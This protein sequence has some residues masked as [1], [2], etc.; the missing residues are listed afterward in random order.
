M[1]PALAVVTFDFWNTLACEPPGLLL[2]RRVRALSNAQ[3][4]RPVGTGARTSC[5]E[6]GRDLLLGIR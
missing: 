4:K 1:T 3:L 5:Q 2:E 6:A